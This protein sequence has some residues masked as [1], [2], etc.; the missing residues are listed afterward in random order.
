MEKILILLKI[1]VEFIIIIQ[2][3]RYF[4]KTNPVTRGNRFESLKKR[5]WPNKSAIYQFN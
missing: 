5:A 4:I 3:V 2:F 1:F